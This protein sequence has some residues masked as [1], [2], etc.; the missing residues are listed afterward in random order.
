WYRQVSGD[1]VLV[2]DI[3]ELDDNNLIDL[4]ATLGLDTPD[5]D[6]VVYAM[7][8][9]LDS[10]G[11]YQEVLI[12]VE[13]LELVGDDT[14]I[15]LNACVR[16]DAFFNDEAPLDNPELFSIYLD[17]NY[18]SVPDT[19]VVYNLLGQYTPFD[20]AVTGWQC[21]DV[22]LPL[23]HPLAAETER[24]DVAMWVHL[25]YDSLSFSF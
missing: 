8:A 23:V 21:V 7:A 3:S 11:A 12:P 13:T 20:P 1:Q 15:V 18:T 2:E 14:D 4:Y 19:S 16:L 9:D 6:V 25:Q 17:A 22:S 10:R 5:D 24:F